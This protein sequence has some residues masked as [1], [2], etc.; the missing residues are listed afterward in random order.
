MKTPWVKFL[1]VLHGGIPCKWLILELPFWNEQIFCACDLDNVIQASDI[2][3]NRCPGDAGFQ[4]PM[5]LG[6][7]RQFSRLEGRW[8]E[9]AMRKVFNITLTST[10]FLMRSAIALQVIPVVLSWYRPG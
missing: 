9:E 8:E 6:E 5:F 4:R 3:W 2:D 1:L 10:C 7:R